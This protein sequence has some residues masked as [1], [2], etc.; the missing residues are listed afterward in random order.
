V[1]GQVG[2][3]LF[4][5]ALAEGMA[6]E[7]PEDLLNVYIAVVGEESQDTQFGAVETTT[8]GSRPAARA[9]IT[10]ETTEGFALALDLG[11]GRLVLAFGVTPQ[12]EL[13]PTEPLLLAIIESITF[14]AGE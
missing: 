5:P 11:E 13:A 10:Q 12:G 7:T 2:L 8:V 6:A 9:S 14:A 3:I 4:Q 1:A